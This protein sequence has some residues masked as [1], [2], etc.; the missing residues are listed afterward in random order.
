M[1]IVSGKGGY[2]TFGAGPESANIHHWT[3]SAEAD[4]LPAD[5]FGVET[6]AKVYEQG[7]HKA[8]GTIEGYVAIAG[9][10]VI[11]ML[12][13][14]CDAGSTLKLA[15]AGGADGTIGYQMANVI[16]NNVS[17]NVE[18]RGGLQTWSCNYTSSS[19]LG[20]TVSY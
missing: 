10:P 7:M 6:D 11:S 4:L 18:K 19:A 17:V 16:I 15:L 8:T 12:Q 2:V 5:V 20:V 1:A 3:Y 9:V 14:A 13:T